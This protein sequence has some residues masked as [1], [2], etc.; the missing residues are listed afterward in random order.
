MNFKSECSNCRKGI[1][2]KIS[3]T[4]FVCS[5]CGEIFVFEYLE[6]P[7]KKKPKSNKKIRKKKPINHK[8]GKTYS[9]FLQTT[10]WKNMSFKIKKRDGFKCT[11]CGSKENL[12]VHHTTY[13]HVGIEYKHKKDLLTLC[14]KCH[15][16]AHE[17][18][19]IT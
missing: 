5:S 11:V 4:K 10:Y 16:M 6:K 7:K 3:K 19:E 2:I 1:L 13:K 8:T 12:Q 17:F 15:T 14:G 18:M 9:Q